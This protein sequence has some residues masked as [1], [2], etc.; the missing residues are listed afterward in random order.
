[1]SRP[2]TLKLHD[3]SDESFIHGCYI[4]DYICDDLIK[5]FDE[6]PDRQLSGTIL[7]EIDA[8]IKDMNIANIMLAPKI[9]KIVLNMGLGDAKLNKNGL[10]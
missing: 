10:K 9:E 2:T 8:L 3:F 1:M 6:H 5:Y 4:P 7:N